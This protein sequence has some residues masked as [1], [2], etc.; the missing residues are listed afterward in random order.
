[1]QRNYKR[2]DI[3][4]QKVRTDFV[5]NVIGTQTICKKDLEGRQ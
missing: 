3:T 2:V 5:E 4:Q 1:M